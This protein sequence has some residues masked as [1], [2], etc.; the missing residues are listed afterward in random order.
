MVEDSAVKDGVKIRKSSVG[1]TQWKNRV[2][3]TRITNC[4]VLYL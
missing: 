3:C 4:I 1:G 2:A